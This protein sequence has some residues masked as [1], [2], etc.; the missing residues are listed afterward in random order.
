LFPI[1]ITLK[2]D[3]M[4]WKTHRAWLGAFLAGSILLAAGA[5]SAQETESASSRLVKA[6]RSQVGVTV[7]YNPAYVR[8]SYP[9]GDV[10]PEQG[11][12]TDVI[13]RAYRKALDIDLQKLVHEDMK[14]SF[15]SYPRQWGLKR[16]DPNIDHRR[17][18]NLQKLFARKGASLP[19][20]SNPEDYHPGDL[21]TQILPGELPHIAIVSDKRSADGKSPLVIHNIGS[22]AREE[23][24]L[25]TFTITG[26]YRFVTASP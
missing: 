14:A 21:I 5:S 4:N 19:V 11:V 13:V 18:P 2:A 25:F 1:R 20:T 17:V 22:G 15:D 24:R 7:T 26:H 8:L 16:P 10:A 6:A 9:G 12:C 23:D 3:L